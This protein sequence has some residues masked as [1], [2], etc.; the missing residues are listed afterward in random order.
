MLY[1]LYQNNA[2]PL[3]NFRVATFCLVAEDSRPSFKFYNLTQAIS[4]S[5]FLY[6]PAFHYDIFDI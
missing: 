3:M 5:F 2:G 1:N 6:Y 4:A